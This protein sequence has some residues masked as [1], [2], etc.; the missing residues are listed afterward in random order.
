[1]RLFFHG[2]G[3]TGKQQAAAALAGELKAPLLI[4][5][6]AEALNR[7]QDFRPLLRRA[8]REARMQEAILC[9]AEVDRLQTEEQ[10]SP[11]R[12]LILVLSDQEAGIVIL[13]GLKPWTPPASQA[14]GVLNCSFSW[15]DFEHRRQCWQLGLAWLGWQL[16][17]LDLDDLA[18]RFSLTPVQIREATLVAGQQEMAGEEGALG[19]GLEPVRSR[20]GLL[21]AAA[22]S[23]CGHE[24]QALTHRL[25]PRYTWGDIVLPEDTLAQ[26][27][28]LCQR[29]K[30]RHR[31]LEEWGFDG[32]LSLGKGTN[33]L[34]AG[35]SGTGKTMAAE[36]IARELGLDLYK[37]DLPGVV[38]K[39]IGETE[40][41]L[42]RIFSAAQNANAILF[43][44]EADALFGKRSEV[45]DSHDRYANIEI[46]YLLQKMEEYEGLA[47]L[48]TNMRQHLD[49]AFIRRLAMTVLFPFP[50]EASRRRIWDGI[51]PRQTP[52]AKDMDLEGLARKYK[53]S[54][55][56]IKNIAL[57][58]A[59]LAAADGGEVAMGHLLQAVRREY[60]KMGKAYGTVSGER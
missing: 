4:L 34:F 13:T 49:E 26:L 2:P 40:K 57:A 21:F 42:D 51:W 15:P 37:I 45:K 22:R 38:S 46:S 28:E 41:N 47:I 43:F 48:A 31:V 59:F 55:G 29:A 8:F 39:Y 30:H 19:L 6:V 14:L 33:A 17:D 3:G 54:G 27:R 24:L 20:Q 35:P 16:P 50:D 7:G 10:A 32:K 56:N 12:D 1:L 44:D 18:G 11:Y 58:A 36:I 52:L 53:L 23:Q 5:E 60:Q 9:L 25:D